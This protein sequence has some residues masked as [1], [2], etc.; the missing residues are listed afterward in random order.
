MSGATITAF[1]VDKLTGLNGRSLGSTTTDSAGNFSLRVRARGNPVRIQASGGNFVSEMNGATIGSPSAISALIAKPVPNTIIAGI[2]INPLSEFISSLT[3]GNLTSSS[4]AEV[5]GS[6]SDF[7]EALTAATTTIEKIYALTADP[8]TV[9]PDYT[10]GS[11]GTN[12]GNLGIVLG[13]LIN[14]DQYLCPATPGG[15]VTALS[16]DIQDGIFDGAI[17]GATIPYCGSTLKSIAGTSQFQ[18]ASSGL[19][20]LAAVTQAFAF[21]GTGNVLTANGVA[22]VA[23]DGPHVY[24]LAPLAQ[25]NTSLTQAA[26]PSVNQF[27]KPQSAVMNTARQDSTGASLK[28]GMVLLAGG[29]NPA[30]LNSTELYDPATNAFAVPQNATMNAPRGFA[31]GTLLPSGNVLIAGGSNHLP[32]ALSSSELYIAAKNCFAGQPGSACA[33]QSPPPAMNSPHQ[34]ATANLLSNG[35]VLIAGGNDGF[36]NLTLCELYHPVNNCFA[37]NAGTPCS[38][39]QP[40]RMVIPRD[41]ATGTLLP[42]GKVLVAGGFVVSDG[43]ASVELYDSAQN[44]FAG[45]AG[46]PCENQSTPIMKVKRLLASAVLLANGKVLIVGGFNVSDGV[47]ASTELYDPD[48]NCFAGNAGTPCA[49]LTTP[50]MNTARQVPTITL[51]PNGKVLVA[52]GQ[53]DAFESLASTELY[54]PVNNC[55]AGNP[56]TPCSGQSSPDMNEARGNDFGVL[57]SNGKVLISGGSN[58]VTLNS[59]DL[60]TP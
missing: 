10:A 41:V 40:P 3:I 2:V 31:T 47:L 29:R 36:G 19:Q 24:P 11:V 14:E 30:F 32:D 21:G 16:S 6:A 25:I 9:V 13:A 17:F 37:G 59:T 35:K 28:S 33:S 46:T 51:L 5:K 45:R 38:S 54:D 48:N 60:Y 18:D 52:G 23:I 56:G 53:N 8:S 22:D 15:L 27:A 34:L 44:C 7:E 39:T 43:A 26:P 55:F 58:S 1:A 57:L 12:A 4:K 20:Q 42:N 49:G 50:T